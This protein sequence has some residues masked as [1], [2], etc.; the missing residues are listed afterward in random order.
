LLQTITAAFQSS[1]V[2][3]DA[4][5]TLSTKPDGTGPYKF[6]SYE[7][8]GAML[9]TRNPDYFEAGLPKIAAA[10]LLLPP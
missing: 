5:D 7:P 4:G 3:R 8:N 2:P 1:I 9:L 6:L 10:A